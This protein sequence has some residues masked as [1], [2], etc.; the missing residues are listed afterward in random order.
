MV[1]LPATK[2]SDSRELD[3]SL[4]L[5]NVAPGEHTVAVRVQ[6]DYDNQFTGK[7]VVK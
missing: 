3:Y 1:A 4:T 2:L 7:V 6:D 5:N